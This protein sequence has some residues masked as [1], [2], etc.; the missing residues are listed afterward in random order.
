MK[1]LIALFL[2]VLLCTLLMSACGNDDKAE[3]NTESTLAAEKNENVPE[4][5][6]ITYYADIV[7]KNYGTITVAL[8]GKSA[9]ITV[10]NFVKLANEGFYD[11]LKFHR[12]IEGFMMQGGNGESA[13]KTCGTIKGEFYANGVSNPLTHVRGAISMAR[14]SVMDSASSQF[15]IVHEDSTYLDGQY[16][17]FGYVTAGLNIVDAVCKDSKPTDNNGTIANA[18]QPVIV[19]VKIREGDKNET[20]KPESLVPDKVENIPAMQEIT[21]YADIIIKDYGTI[22][23][24][25]D[26][27]S[28]PITVENF[29]KLAKEDFYDGL[30]FHRI[31]ENFMMQGGNGEPAGKSCGTIK[32]EFLSNGVS[33]PLTHVRG[34]ISMA[35][36]SIPDSASSQ[37]FIVHEDSTY[38]DGQYAAFGYVTAGLNIVDAVCRDAQPVDGNGSIAEAAQPIILDVIIREAK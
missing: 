14:T 3:G 32:G 1:R 31:I 13:G 8:D 16:A 19:T 34:A 38:L 21:C 18:D 23:V 37:F 25:L 29:V 6:E 24:A 12:I 27:K 20:E 33:N 5:A 9:P 10:K 17:A 28:A 26:A 11:G 30:K 22:T 4:M 2:S 35:R 36:T 15:F 7:I